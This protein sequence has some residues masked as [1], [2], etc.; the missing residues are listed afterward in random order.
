MKISKFLATTSAI[1]LFGFAGVANAA[2]SAT[3]FV[4]GNT[5]AS[6]LFGTGAL[7]VGAASTFTVSLTGASAVAKRITFTL[8]NAVFSAALTDGSLTGTC[9]TGGTIASGGTVG[10]NTV[11]YN[12]A[13]AACA[14]ASTFI[15]AVP[16]LQPTTALGTAGTN[17]TMSVALTDQATPAVAIDGG[18]TDSPRTLM[19]SAKAITTT[20]TAPAARELTANSGFT[21]FTAAVAAGLFGAS[22]ATT[23]VI[24]NI[25][26]ASSGTALNATQGAALT[27]AQ[28]G[29]TTSGT[30]T[31]TGNF[32]AALADPAGTCTN[33]IYI[34][35]NDDG[36]CTLAAD[37]VAT[38]PTATTASIPLTLTQ[39]QA[40]VGADRDIRLIV[41]GTTRIEPGTPTAV[42]A[43]NYQDANFRDDSFASVNLSPLNLNGATVT[44]PFHLAAADSGSSYTSRVRVVNTSTLPARILMSVDPDNAAA[45]NFTIL[46]AANTTGLFPGNA[47]AFDAD[48]LLLPGR[49]LELT[50]AQIETITGTTVTSAHRARVTF[51]STQ[52]GATLQA[53]PYI[54]QPGGVLGQIGVQISQ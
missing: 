23:P 12:I 25:Q 34:D 7:P 26:L 14:A 54:V 22:G 29:A 24:G 42:L 3:G 47:T 18:V 45:S 28:A 50:N 48:G 6:E 17:V 8:N 43:I 51:V 19:T 31:L 5:P 38:S 27:L 1:A 9:G 44:V 11:T 2:T 4:P 35:L 39:L 40:L 30:L 13:A 52:A 15:L 33:G 10:S 53:T 49:A 32:S 16:A 46:T 41:D 21:Q 36:A 20:I 37:A